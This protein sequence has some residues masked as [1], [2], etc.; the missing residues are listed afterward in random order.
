MRHD[1]QDP[2]TLARCSSDR[3]P[4]AGCNLVDQAGGL[5]QE[6]PDKGLGPGDP[7]LREDVLEPGVARAPKLHEPLPV[8]GAQVV[9]HHGGAE[10]DLLRDP[11]LHL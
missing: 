2:D 8:E 5:A 10:S 7:F 11:S 6:G 3:V 1:T 4:D 9:V